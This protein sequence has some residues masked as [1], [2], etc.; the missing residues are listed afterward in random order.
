MMN[1]D[2]TIRGY[3]EV[4]VKTV[5][6]NETLAR[7]IDELTGFSKR[8]ADDKTL[9]EAIEEDKKKLKLK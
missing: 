4:S 6:T 7:K 3:K 5:K 1:L 9:Q 8:C 2:R